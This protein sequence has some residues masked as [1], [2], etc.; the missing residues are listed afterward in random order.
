MNL[1]LLFT[2]LS[3]TLYFEAKELHFFADSSVVVLKDS[4]RIKKENTELFSDSLIFYRETAQMK[5]IGNAILIFGKDTL[6]GDSIYYNTKTKNGFA[7]QGKIKQEKGL[8]SGI[9][10]AKD[11]TDTIYVWK[12]GFTTCE[13][14]IPHYHFRSLQSKIVK[15]DIAIAKPVVLEVHNV[16]LIAVPFWMFPLSR[17]RKSGFMVPRFGVNSADGKY[18]KNLSYYFVINQYSDLTLSLELYEKRGIRG[19]GEFVFVKHRL[20]NINLNSSVAQEWSPWRKRW[21]LSGNTQLGPFNGLRITGKGEYMSDNEILNDYADVKENWLRRELTSYLSFSRNFGKIILTGTIDGR[22]N[23]NTKVRTS[24]LPQIQ[25]GLP[26]VRFGNFGASGNISFLREYSRKDTTDTLRWGLKF[27]GSLNYNLKLF[28]YLRF[29]IQGNGFAGIADYDTTGKAL[30]VVKS[31][32]TSLSFSTVLYGRTLFGFGKIKYFTHT[33]QPNI[34]LYYQPDIK[35]PSVNYYFISSY[36]KELLSLNLSFNNSFGVQ[37]GEKK[38]DF[39]NLTLST[40][41]NLIP[42]G[43]STPFKLW[44]ISLNSLTFRPATIRLSATYNRENGKIEN[45]SLNLSM[46]AALPLPL[47]NLKD[48]TASNKLSINLNYTLTRTLI[49]SQLLSAN[50]S[51][52][53]GKSFYI[54]MNGTYDFSKKEIISKSFNVKKDLHCWEASFTYNSFGS[55][56]DYNFRVYIKKLP[57]V[58]IEKSIFDLFLP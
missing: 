11:S 14:T 4:V 37:L 9:S 56:W 51:F 44:Q 42:K 29:T 41:S 32:S 3:S 19:L 30:P 47:F 27:S 20:G 15:D 39:V 8:Y 49:T 34:R 38:I 26:P 6:Y 50:G 48:T 58:K 31:Y 24:H 1:I 28:R 23:L 43:T 25:I 52:N 53:F 57:D 13:A 22:F 55:R 40:S 33:L 21:T 10:V 35:N 18:I 2:I 45:P 7:F 16:P 46:S 36:T 54:T 12:G 5:A 17:E